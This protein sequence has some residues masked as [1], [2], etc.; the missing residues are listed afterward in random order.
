[1]ALK[2][3][4]LTVTVRAHRFC[5]KNLVNFF[6]KTVKALVKQSYILSIHVNYPCKSGIYSCSTP[7][8]KAAF[9]VLLAALAAEDGASQAVA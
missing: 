1:M 8:P 5:S 7:R 3:Q 4:R 9:A 2:L 6:L